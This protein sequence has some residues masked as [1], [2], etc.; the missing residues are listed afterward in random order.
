[1]KIDITQLEQEYEDYMYLASGLT[2]EHQKST[3]DALISKAARIKDDIIERE[4]NI[5]E[6]FSKLMEGLNENNR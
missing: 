5:Q 3:R 2:Q 6:N 1:M 4:K